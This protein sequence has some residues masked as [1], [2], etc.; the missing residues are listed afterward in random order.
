MAI[1]HSF[2]VTDP[3]RNSTKEVICELV[4]RLRVSRINTEVLLVEHD[5]LKIE[6]ET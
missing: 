1:V 3:G 5:I 6:D 4:R 2:T